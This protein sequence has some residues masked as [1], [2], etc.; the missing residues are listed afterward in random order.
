MILNSKKKNIQK[1]LVYNYI[2]LTECALTYSNGYFIQ[3]D[4]LYE[5]FDFE[6]Q[7]EQNFYSKMTFILRVIRGHTKR[8]SLYVSKVWLPK[9]IIN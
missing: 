2:S 7:E 1:L 3:T 8:V 6:G 4:N 9:N 5:V